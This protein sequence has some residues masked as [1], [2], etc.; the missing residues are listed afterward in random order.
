MFPLQMDLLCAIIV[1]RGDFVEKWNFNKKAILW[2]LDDTLH[3]RVEAARKVFPGMFRQCLYENRSDAFI[4][5]AVAYM[6]TQI[7]RKSM[8]HEDAFQALLA[9]YPSDKPYVREECVSY[10]Y[11]HIRDFAVPFAETMEIIR[12]L[13]AQGV[14]MAIVTNITPELL[15]HQH[16]KVEMLG[17]APLF[18]AIVYSAEV[19]AH[20]PDRRIYDHAAALLGVSNADCLF[21]GD[22]PDS[23][24][25]GALAADME[26]VWLDRWNCGDRFAGNDRVHRVQTAAEYFS[27]VR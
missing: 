15:E 20:K 21:V 1:A 14:K 27:N 23:D 24:V 9:R 26:V 3:S 7:R 16:K 12:K 2:D 22:D 25:A 19:G 17:I 6:M 5:E 18:D 11:M 8:V 13:K 4:D 10:Y